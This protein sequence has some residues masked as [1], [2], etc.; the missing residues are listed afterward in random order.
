M[1]EIGDWSLE[2]RV[3]IQ[4][5][6]PRPVFIP[7]SLNPDHFSQPLLPEPCELEIIKG[8]AYSLSR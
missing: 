2:S 8:S 5:Q 1:S 6:D 3:S 7:H 4:T